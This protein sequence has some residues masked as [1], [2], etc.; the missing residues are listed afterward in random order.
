MLY[1]NFNHINY[2]NEK[3]HTIDLH[4]F[5]KVLLQDFQI[6]LGCDIYFTSFYYSLKVTKLN[7]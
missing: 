2:K 7:L 5:F 3:K 6:N 1:K 4:H